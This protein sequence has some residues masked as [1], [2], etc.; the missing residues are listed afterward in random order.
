[1]KIIDMDSE[2][3]SEVIIKDA[4]QPNGK[5]LIWQEVDVGEKYDIEIFNYDS[6]MRSVDSSRDTVEVYFV[7]SSPFLKIKMID[8]KIGDVY[9]YYP[10]LP[11]LLFKSPPLKNKKK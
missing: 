8:Y 4:N 5:V 7:L 3:L 10:K 6:V 9:I 1:M 2:H 11:Y